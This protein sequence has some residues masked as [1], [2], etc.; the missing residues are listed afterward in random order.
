MLLGQFAEDKF[1]G[2]GLL[3]QG[4]QDPFG[5]FDFLVYALP[6]IHIGHVFEANAE[7]IGLFFIDGLD[8]RYPIDGFQLDEAEYLMVRSLAYDAPISLETSF[9]Q[10]ASHPLTDGIL[11]IVGKYETMRM[12]YEVPSETIETLK[13]LGRDFMYIQT[14][15]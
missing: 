7:H 14:S 5:L 10:M 11:D 4:H 12:N 9:T 3:L 13:Q 1:K 2:F 15:R 8:P 6:Q